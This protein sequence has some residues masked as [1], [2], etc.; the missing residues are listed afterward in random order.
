MVASNHDQ[1]GGVTAETK[2]TTRQGD[3]NSM[4]TE[5]KPPPTDLTLI[6]T[7]IL[8][9][10]GVLIAIIIMVVCC[11]RKG[12]TMLNFNKN[13]WTFSK[14]PLDTTYIKIS[15]SLPDLD[16]SDAGSDSDTKSIR[17]SK[18]LR[19]TTLP[20][21]PQ[22]HWSFQRQMAC[23][24]DLS[25]IEFSV[26]SVKHKE[27]PTLGKLKPEL[28][29][30]AI[31]ESSSGETRVCGQLTFSMKYEQEREA[32]IINV[33]R[34]QGLPAK[35]FS[36]TSD[37]YVK[38]YLLPDRKKKFQTKVHRKTLDPEFNE[39]FVFPL[40][41]S[42]LGQR[43]L[44]FSIYDFDRFSRHDLIGHVVVKDLLAESDLS[45]ETEITKDVLY[46]TQEKVDLGELM[47]SLCYLPTAGRLTVTMVKARNLKAMDVMGAS[48]PYV[49]VAL[50]CQG[51]RIKKKKTS[52][53]K[54]TLNPVYNEALVFDVPQEN[55]EDVSLIIKVIDYD[56]VGNNELIGCCA[57]GP[58]Y[59]GLGYDHWYEMLESP[60][61]PIARWYV[62][63][64]HV[65]GASN[66]KTPNGK[67][68]LGCSP[69]QKN[70]ILGCSGK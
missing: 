67:H 3:I 68:I 56:R 22:R 18:V 49:K 65:P 25:K 36:G 43:M 45:K 12:K 47:L 28:Y 6:I 64:E 4:M 60:R 31:S 46:N 32:L 1:L 51:K 70:L 34:A 13:Q 27:Q 19:Q 26:Q 33:L 42:D 21:V 61:K 63:Q 62:L 54:N 69:G 40:P 11:R 14:T 38:V 15:H 8:V 50:M 5:M 53:K 10:C 44:Q 39:L 17:S 58:C 37:P 30:Y 41:Y 9:V 35:D 66:D 57:V 24:V 29:R 23:Q 59:V 16:K 7:I 2:G 55:V 20:T 48:D 52:V